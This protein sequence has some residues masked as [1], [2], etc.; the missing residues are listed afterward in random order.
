MP[1]PQVLVARVGAVKTVLAAVDLLI[2][3]VLCGV[4]VQAS[5]IKFWLI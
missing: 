3:P 1:A 4:G 5:I 2:V